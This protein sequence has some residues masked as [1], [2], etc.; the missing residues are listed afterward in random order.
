MAKYVGK[1]FK[2]N[3]AALKIKRNG[4]HYVHVTWFNP[5]TKRFRCKVI[6]SLEDKFDLKDKN[7]RILGA[8]PFHKVSDDIYCVFS[9]GKYER[10]RAGK[11]SPISVSKTKGFNIW[12]GYEDVKTVH[13]SALKGKAQKHLSILK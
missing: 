2:V 8:G 13:I 10:L 4:A 6:T 9:K 3:N 5:F 11:I 1:I 12:I 7:K